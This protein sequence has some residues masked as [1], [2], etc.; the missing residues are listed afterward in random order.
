MLD[1]SAKIDSLVNKALAYLEEN[2]EASAMQVVEEILTIDQLSAKAVHILGLMAV[3]LGEI[4]KAR[5][6]FTKAV[7][8]APDKFEH[9]EILAIINAKLGLLTESLFYGKLATALKPYDGLEGL[10]PDW[11][12]SFEEN[13]LAIKEKPHF[14]L[15][16]EC[17][18]KGNFQQA[19]LYFQKAAELD[20]N[21]EN[22]WRL[23]SKSLRISDRS[24]ESLLMLKKLDNIGLNDPADLSEVALVMADM[25]LF[26]EAFLC[27]MEVLK[28]A[29]GDHRLFSNYIFSLN[30]SGFAEE[31]ILAEG[32]WGSLFLEPIFNHD[33]D[34]I[35]TTYKDHFKVGLVSGRFNSKGG[36]DH[37]L[38]I[39]IHNDNQKI[40]FNCYSYNKFDDIISRKIGGA[41]NAWTDLKD[42]DDKT[43]ATIIYNDGNDILI[44]L[45][46]NL[47]T[48]NPK[49]F[50]YNPA[51]I[52]L[53]YLG[54]NKS[55]NDMGFT[56]VFG[57]NICYNND[58]D[59]NGAIIDGNFACFSPE[60]KIED[61]SPASILD[62]KTPIFG[63]A[64]TGS[65]LSGSFYEAVKNICAEIPNARILLNTRHLG[66]GG[67]L[68][69]INRELKAYGID[70]KVDFSI[71]DNDR[72]AAISDFVRQCDILLVFDHMRSVDIAWE[73]FHEIKPVF[74]L[75]G[76]LPYLRETDDILNMLDMD[77]WRFS[78]MDDM[79]IKLSKLFTAD[80]IIY[81]KN[82]KKLHK[83]ITKATDRKFLQSQSLKFLT[84]LAN[85]RKEFLS[86]IT[87]EKNKV[88]N[89]N[90]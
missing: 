10:L 52:I 76:N 85:Y 7:E 61:L 6:L 75:T 44:D 19:I 22:I 77:E 13:F 39:I 82:T 27:H 15:G 79:L 3:K 11:L 24:Y 70:D 78:N 16:K 33:Y 34:K 1:N 21:D 32:D 30:K 31:T 14:T 9:S 17:Y 5:D 80:G 20:P 83:N 47:E 68:D 74:I 12:G 58:D 50:A 48:S 86:L 84:A 72:N 73:F 67:I 42:V 46:A 64:P 54:H 26:E 40:K 25:G 57:S 51:P 71:L 2:Q 66:G 49:V 90:G 89:K 8:L 69:G 41:V 45:D 53:K 37:I 38:P 88:V 23:L 81:M 29:A 36:L 35:I 4:V 65:E 59:I 60:I 43:A 62:I 87:N 63:I 18:D 56:G 55:A 28:H